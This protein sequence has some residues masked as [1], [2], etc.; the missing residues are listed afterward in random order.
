M[1]ADTLC[2]YR[3]S[4]NCHK[5]PQ[6]NVGLAYKD[7]AG[8]LDPSWQTIYS[9]A[10]YSVA[11]RIHNKRNLQYHFPISKCRKTE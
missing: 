8:D 10:F 2:A 5:F 3:L 11:S 7:A 6:L 1:I 4:R 9:L